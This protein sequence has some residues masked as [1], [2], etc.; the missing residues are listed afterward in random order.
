LAVT[1]WVIVRAVAATFRAQNLLSG[2]SFSM[3]RFV[4]VLLERAT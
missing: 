4:G 2:Q 1:A 3:R